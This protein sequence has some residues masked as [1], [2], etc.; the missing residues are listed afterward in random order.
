MGHAL[1]ESSIRL[2]QQATI[3]KYLF[4]GS[5]FESGRGYKACVIMPEIL[6]VLESVHT[7]VTAFGSFVIVRITPTVS[8]NK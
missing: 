1:I 3:C 7:S 8:S 4:V 6:V 5:S 2:L